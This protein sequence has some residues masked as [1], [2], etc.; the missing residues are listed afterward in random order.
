MMTN[1][2]GDAPFGG[3]IGRPAEDLFP[4]SQTDRVMAFDVN[5]G[6]S[7]VADNFSPAVFATGAG[8]WNYDGNN[9]TETVVR[10]VA[11]FE[12]LD[13][14]GRLQPLLGHYDES[15]QAFRGL[16]WH[17]DTTEKPILGATEIWEIYNFTGDAHPIH[18]HQ[19]NF[20][21]LGRKEITFDVDEDNPIPV[22]QHNGEEGE[23][24]NVYNVQV[25]N[26]VSLGAADGYVENA[27]KD[28]VTALPSQVTRIKASF[29][30]PGR[31]VWHCH[32]LSHEDHE[33]M[34]VLEVQ[35]GVAQGDGR[36]DGRREGGRR[37]RR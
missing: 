6:L 30:K 19:V 29:E 27:P 12:G 3:D 15:A 9:R 10:K 23:H 31:Y 4:D 25:G 20:E 37:R 2:L 8:K 24:P 14:F 17:I 21:I 22:L 11:L 26:P 18:L 16:G 36:S 28:M 13:E 5:Q 33:M 1:S 35:I 32:I 7:N 34:R